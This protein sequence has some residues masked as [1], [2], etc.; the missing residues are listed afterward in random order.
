MPNLILF[1]LPHFWGR[2]PAEAGSGLACRLPSEDKRVLINRRGL[3]LFLKT[4][5]FKQDVALT[6]PQSFTSRRSRALCARQKSV[7][8]LSYQPS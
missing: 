2:I 5:P 4:I 1:C 6:V 3:F 7:H 8:G